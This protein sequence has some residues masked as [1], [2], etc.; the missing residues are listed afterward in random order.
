MIV[1]RALR[2]RML[3]TYVG[4]FAA[5]LFV[6]AVAVHE[7]FA[8][9]LQEQITARL[10]ALAGAGVTDVAFTPTSFQVSRNVARVLRP[11][12]EGLQWFDARSS[13]IASFGLTP[14][15]G[16]P[17]ELHRR[18]S[19]RLGD[20]NLATYTVALRNRAGAVRG[21][22]R[23]G[24]ADTDYVETLR[25]L[26]V[27]LVLGSLIAL[28]LTGVAGYVLSGQATKRTE[29]EIARLAAFTA[30]A[31]HELR[32]PLTAI[33]SNVEA[34]L[35]ED[36][37]VPVHV[38]RRLQA[39]LDAAIQLRRLSDDLLLIAQAG[40]PLERELFVVDVS[41]TVRRVH[42]LYA[43]LARD[44]GVRLTVTP[45]EARVYGSPDLLQRIVSNLVDN[46]IR[47]TGAGGLVTVACAVEAA[48]VVVR[49]SDTG[50]GIREDD[51]RRI[52]ERFW[53]VDPA[54]SEARGAGLGLS[55]ALALAQRHGGSIAVTSQLG[56]GSTFSLSL[57][58]IVA[59][60]G[61]TLPLGQPSLDARPP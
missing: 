28:A 38:R 26:D 54:R 56:R 25:R 57:P 51:Q 24:A 34:T 44:R 18:E 41:S 42:E 39:V 35:R 13:L 20:R 60:G 11:D 17:P 5:T 2:L 4:I 21:Y 43:E 46:A 50:V 10:A 16:F 55:V 58:R 49:V 59:A 36:A 23:A 8:A 27:D 29:A 47:Y 40:Q 3:L 1:P 22:V 32:G 14:P 52:F 61:F 53:R 7:T 19:F 9:S 33:A 31:S 30:D 45:C 15:I 37:S 48:N 6:F 12:E